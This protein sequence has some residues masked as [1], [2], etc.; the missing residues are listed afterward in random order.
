LEKLITATGKTFDCSYFNVFAPVAQVNISIVNAS[1]VTLASVFSNPAETVQLWY[2][3]QYLAHHT[4]LIA[5]V[6]DG[7]D[8]R[9]VL[10]KE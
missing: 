1:F 6:N 5:I 4:K 9:V 7:D 3:D 10:G 2:G 8:I